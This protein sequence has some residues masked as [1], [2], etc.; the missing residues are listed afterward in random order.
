[1]RIGFMV[2]VLLLAAVSW[3]VIEG[4]SNVQSAVFEKRQ[5]LPMDLSFERGQARTM[6]NT[7]REAM[8]MNILMQNDILDQAAQ[9]HAEYLV[10]NKEFAHEEIRGHKNFTGMKPLDRTLHVGYNSLQIS[11]NLSTG[12]ANAKSSIDNLFSAIYHRFGFLDPNIDEMGVGVDQDPKNSL[13]SAFVYVMGNSEL[14][15]LCLSAEFRGSGKYVYGVC[16]NRKYRIRESTF[17]NAMN[18]KKQYN[19]KIIVYPYDGQSNIPVAFYNETPD[20][21]P[22]HKVSGFPIS[23]EFNDYYFDNVEV[24]S[25]KLYKSGHV[26]IKNVLLMN[27]QSDPNLKFNAKQFALF[28]LERLE[29]NTEYSVVLTYAVD[30]KEGELRWSFR[31][32]AP[33]EELYTIVEKEEK[34]TMKRGESYWVYF[35]PLNSQDIITRLTFP[36]GIDIEFVDN[37]TFKLTVMS[38]ELKAFDV[39][40]DHRTLHVRVRNSY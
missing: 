4:Q 38:K 25:F 8:H 18:L 28:P 22:Q 9:N 32:T 27:E 30:R 15:R 20:P 34:V 13:N 26:E 40:T 29:F 1:M 33:K 5:P 14:N 17:Q 3:Q 24:R 35:Q 36:S 11:E 21:L 2:V 39:V 12:N 23:V 6:V 19:P 16:E 10:A 7:L 31:T 37:S